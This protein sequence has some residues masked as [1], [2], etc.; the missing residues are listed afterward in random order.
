MSKLKRSICVLLVLCM[1]VGAMGLGALAAGP[2]LPFTD[3]PMNW[4]YPGVRFVYENDIMTGTTA[5]TF[6]P[7]A[8]FTRA[9]VVATLFR[10]Y[11]ERQANTDDPTDTPF[12]DVGTQWFAAYVAWAYENDIAEGAGGNFNPNGAVTR[13][14][15][16][17]MLYR[18]EINMNDLNTDDITASDTWEEFTDLNQ[19][20]DWAYDALLWANAEGLIL[21]LAGP[22]I[23][24]RGTATRAQAA[25]IL[26]RFLGG[27][28]TP[29]EPPIEPTTFDVTEL[30]G[31]DADVDALAVEFGEVIGSEEVYECD[32]LY[33][34]ESGLLVIICDLDNTII[35]VG[36]V[37]LD[38]L[39]N[40]L[41]A[42]NLDGWD[43]TSTYE[44]VYAAFGEPDFVDAYDSYF[45]QV[46]AYLYEFVFDGD[47]VIGVMVHTEYELILA[48]AGLSTFAVVL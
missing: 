29:P 47:Y 48:T 23:A 45:F 24:P 40:S 16:A 1:V 32:T 41:T 38:E 19:I 9:Q 25:I 26:T 6:A 15:F 7:Q 34:F 28:T 42:L 43:G 8:N 31:Q 14:Q 35:S 3:V 33:V 39:G 37:Y 18:F 27:D 13:Q 2:D 20:N 17:T 10:I 46:G 21:G 4:M 30:L 22:A 11:N 44:E 36:V 12:G 5:T